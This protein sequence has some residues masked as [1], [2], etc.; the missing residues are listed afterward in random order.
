MTITFIRT[1]IL[2]LITIIALRI[3]GKRQ[4]GELSPTEL[5]VTI[6]ISD[7]AA[8]PMQDNGIPLL[9]GII[10]I[11]T[12]LSLEIITSTL[13]LKSDK[14]KKLLFGERSATK[15]LKNENNTHFLYD[16]GEVNTP[17][18][19]AK[20]SY[21]GLILGS[22]GEAAGSDKSTAFIT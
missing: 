9:S 2:Y 7:L 10:P 3:M 12:L 5:V 13:A 18:P 17:E 4:V 19:Y 22:D 8:I 21:Q 11:F 15:L 20:R 14:C 16:I 1:I 6:L